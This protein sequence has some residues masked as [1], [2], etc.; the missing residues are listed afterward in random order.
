MND[1]NQPPD[2]ISSRKRSLEADNTSSAKVCR[3]ETPKSEKTPRKILPK[4][5][6]PSDLSG[7]SGL[8]DL[9]L[10][11]AK[12]SEEMKEP[13]P[14]H[15]V[16]PPTEKYVENSIEITGNVPLGTLFTGWG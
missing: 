11:L 16:D 15:Q 6:V 5:D 2:N 4:P 7:L 3:V 12:K 10:E 14:E 9:L 1:K 8:T 13:T